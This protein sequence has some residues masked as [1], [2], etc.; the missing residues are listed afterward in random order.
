VIERVHVEILHLD[1][2][3]ISLWIKKMLQ[4]SILFNYIP[5]SKLISDTEILATP[6]FILR[7]GGAR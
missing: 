7:S 5:Y 2:V 4:V 3:F 1:S 6:L